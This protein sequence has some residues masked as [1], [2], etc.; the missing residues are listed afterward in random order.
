MNNERIWLLL[1]NDK[2]AGIAICGVYVGVDKDGND[3]WNNAIY[4]TLHS[5][6]AKIKRMPRK[7]SM[8]LIGDFN[9][10]I[11]NEIIKKNH[12]KVNGNGHRLLNLASVGFEVVNGHEK[13]QGLWTFMRAPNTKTVVDY[14][15][16][17]DSLIDLVQSLIIMDGGSPSRNPLVIS[18][19]KALCLTIKVPITKIKWNTV[20]KKGWKINSESNWESYNEVLNKELDDKYKEDINID[21]KYQI[22]FDSLHKAGEESI[23]FRKRSTRGKVFRGSEKLQA[24]MRV[25]RQC[26]A[27]WCQAMNGTDNDL[28]GKAQR[29]EKLQSY[30]DV[31][32][33][34]RDLLDTERK[35]EQRKL[36]RLISQKGNRCSSIFWVEAK[37]EPMDQGIT[38]LR[39]KSGQLISDP[40]GVLNF[41]FCYF[42]KLFRRDD[43]RSKPR[44]DLNVEESV[45]DSKGLKYSE[46]LCTEISLKELNNAIENLANGISDAADGIPNEFLK[47]SD[48]NFRICLLDL[49]N[50][51]IRSG[52]VV[53]EWNKGIVFVLHKKGD[54]TDLQNYRGITINPNISKLFTRILE[55][56]L[57]IIVEAEDLLGEFQGAVRKGR[58]TTDNIF[59]LGTILE[60]ARRMK[61]H[62]TAIGFVDMKK[63]YDMVDR[64]KLWEIMAQKG[65]GGKFLNL[66]KSMYEGSNFEVE[67]NGERTHPIF[68]GRGLK[69][70]CVL[71]PILFALYLNDLGEELQKSKLGIVLNKTTISC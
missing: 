19:H 26:F 65:L 55:N 17:E 56:R 35:T 5:E 58:H 63:A 51:I 54:R 24:M 47:E 27:E 37:G 60:K 70:G 18:D 42:D 6:V 62:K 57:M 43:G 49:F 52:R 33:E 16:V 23:G 22:I 40:K 45:H 7:Y 9:A 21:Q 3:Q 61:L 2:G 38:S 29:Q 14:A 71:S 64:E 66:V 59:T 25:R 1:E 67:I 69:Q 28:T 15:L 50:S 46:D 30:L 32:K 44:V 68:P 20:R 8:A 36:G 31:S 10:H 11:G 12:S 4:Q 34:V 53:Q 13:C 39:D 48:G 41:T